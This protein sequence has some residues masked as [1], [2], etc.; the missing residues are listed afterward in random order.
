MWLG[1]IYFPIL[2]CKIHS[3][4]P[5][6]ISIISKVNFYYTELSK[7]EYGWKS[8]QS[9]KFTTTDFLI[10]TA[11]N[12]ILRF[13][14]FHKSSVEEM[15]LYVVQQYAAWLYVAHGGCFYLLLRTTD[16]SHSTVNRPTKGR[17]SFRQP[18]TKSDPSDKIFLTQSDTWYTTNKSC[19]N[20]NQ[21]KKQKGIFYPADKCTV[22]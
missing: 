6:Q 14:S 22:P 7:E 16:D 5:F 17:Q 12:G 1:Y 11:H 8:Q 10:R 2:L 19:W 9:C 20:T 3:K 4:I 13:A 21:S 15:G 18:S